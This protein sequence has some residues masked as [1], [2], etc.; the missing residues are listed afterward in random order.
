MKNY[1]SPP[2][3]DQPRAEKL[4]IFTFLIIILIFTFSSLHFVNAA[5]PQFLI[6]WQAQSYAPSW[7][8]GKIFPI[9]K[10]SI[11]V[12]FELIDSSKLADL[13]K[14]KIRWYIN[15]KLVKNENDGLG[16]KSLKFI[17]PDYSGNNTEI[18]ISIVDYRGSALDRIITIPV[19]SPEVVIDS[20]YPD[21]KI[22]VNSSIFQAI[23][24]FFNIK[25]TNDLSVD[26]SANGQKSQGSFDNPW[27]LN[28]KIDSQIPS[29]FEINI[30]SAVRNISN[31]LE[32]ASK[33]IQLQIK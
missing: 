11:Q 20:P 12:S 21:R 23:P 15:G 32:F 9:N 27:S 33:S 17:A 25:N 8:Q 19:V 24:F 1:N 6:S 18:R 30:Q 28:L 31:Q 22:D 4:K 10:T 26:W 2:N 29:G 16:I 3:A 7:Y 13:S 14:T 5:E